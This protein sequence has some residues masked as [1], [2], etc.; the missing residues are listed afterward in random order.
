MKV[1]IRL[2]STLLASSTSH[3]RR[4]RRGKSTAY[5]SL[6]THTAD[7]HDLVVAAGLV[8]GSSTVDLD[9]CHSER[10]GGEGRKGESG[11]GESEVGRSSR[12]E[13]GSSV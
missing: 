12:T 3:S 6:L 4:R 11:G 9:R 5:S 10:T 8:S 2:V 7:N 1:Q 13:A